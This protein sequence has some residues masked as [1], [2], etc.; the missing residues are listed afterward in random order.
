[1]SNLLWVA[2]KYR[3]FEDLFEAD[4]IRMEIDTSEIDGVTGVL[5][6]FGEEEKAR[7][8]GGEATPIRE[9]DG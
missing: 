5:L 3:K 8:Y 1:M 9:I 2:M 4:N 6:V 7:A